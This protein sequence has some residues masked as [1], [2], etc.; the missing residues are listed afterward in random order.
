VKGEPDIM[1]LTKVSDL[2]IDELKNIIR[3]VVEQTITDLI[4]DPDEG[5]ELR[6]EIQISLK[7]SMESIRSGEKSTV[8]VQQVAENLDIEW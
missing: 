5:L 6:Q 2:S 4:V 1:S 8:S 7:E 3:E